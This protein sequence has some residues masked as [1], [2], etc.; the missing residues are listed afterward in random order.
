MKITEREAARQQI[1][2]ERQ[3]ARENIEEHEKKRE[4]LRMQLELKEQKRIRDEA[5]KQTDIQRRVMKEDH[6]RQLLKEDTERQ[7]RELEEEMEMQC[8]ILQDEHLQTEVI[9]HERDKLR[10]L[11][12]SESFNDERDDVTPPKSTVK[13][14]RSFK[15]NDQKQTEMRNMQQNFFNPLNIT[16][17]KPKREITSCIQKSSAKVNEPSVSSNTPASPRE[18]YVSPVQ[19]WRDIFNAQPTYKQTVH[20]KLS[21]QCR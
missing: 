21:H 11:Q 7:Q 14:N 16:D 10:S 1:E 8:K 5:L 19:T 20:S 15:E 4:Y 13:T 6:E 12:D 18:V 2:F 3:S 9:I 17:E